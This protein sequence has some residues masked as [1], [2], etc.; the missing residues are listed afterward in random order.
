MSPDKN[1]DDYFSVCKGKH[2]GR[3]GLHHLLWVCSIDPDTSCSKRYIIPEHPDYDGLY[4]CNYVVSSK[5][6]SIKK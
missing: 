4:F 3:L 5:R 2:N 6:D 1:I